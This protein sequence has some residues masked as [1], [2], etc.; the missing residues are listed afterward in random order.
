MAEAIVEWLSRHITEL[1]DDRVL[2][3]AFH[4]HEFDICFEVNDHGSHISDDHMGFAFL[5]A[6]GSAILRRPPNDKVRAKAKEDTDGM[7]VMNGG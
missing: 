4:M 1:T 5:V 2:D 3:L 7:R 6:L